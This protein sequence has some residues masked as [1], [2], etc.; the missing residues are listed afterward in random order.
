MDKLPFLKNWYFSSWFFRSQVD[1]LFLYGVQLMH[2]VFNKNIEQ[3][4]CISIALIVFCQLFSGSD[5]VLS[6][7]PN[8]SKQV[9]FSFND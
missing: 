6:L 2:I 4:W 3:V 8:R 5:P 7:K 1:M 9:E